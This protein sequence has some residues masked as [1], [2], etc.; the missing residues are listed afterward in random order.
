MIKL[1]CQPY[2]VFFKKYKIN[3]GDNDTVIHIIS[4]SILSILPIFFLSLMPPDSSLN[5]PTMVQDWHR[6]L[7]ELGGCPLYRP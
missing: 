3:T 2:C 5:Q 7:D 1:P 6:R 4:K